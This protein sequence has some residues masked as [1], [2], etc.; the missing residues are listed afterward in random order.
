MT[1]L[2]LD[3]S[4]K[5]MEDFRMAVLCP[6][7]PQ[8]HEENDTEEC[9]EIEHVHSRKSLVGQGSSLEDP[10]EGCRHPTVEVG[11]NKL[12]NGNGLLITLSKSLQAIWT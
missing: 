10:W 6:H 2:V 1:A 11:R 5:R 3:S 12:V 7:T 8:L 4:W 9:E